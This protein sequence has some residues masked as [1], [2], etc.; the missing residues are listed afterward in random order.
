MIRM[1]GFVVLAMLAGW[2]L[3][4]PVEVHGQKRGKQPRTPKGIV[5]VVGG[6]GGIDTMPGSAKFFLP[7]AGVDHEIVNFVWTHGWGRLLSDLQDTKHVVRKADELAVLIR[8]QK[9][10]QP[11][12]RIFLVAKSGGAGLALL[13]AERLPAECL[14]RLILLSAAVAPTY[15]LRPAL[16]AVRGQL[17][18]FYSHNDQLILRWGTSTFGTIDRHYGPSAGL[19]GFVVPAKLLPEDRELYGKLVQVPWQP[20]MLR[21]GY[22]GTHSGTSMPAFLE[23]EVAPWLK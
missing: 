19:T 4:V 8:R 10:R 5:Y 23:A 15:D 1:G 6:I 12:R 2:L 18:A 9:E 20:R 21:E 17:V 3:V 11:D 14:D 7:R 13:A 16:R 22:V